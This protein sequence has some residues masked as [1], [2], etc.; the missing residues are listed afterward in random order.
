L[1]LRGEAGIGKSA[2]LGHLSQAA[3]GLTVVRCAGVEPEM[4]LPFAGLHELCSPLLSRLDALPEPQRRAVGVALG[5][6]SGASPDRLLVALGALGLLAASAGDPLLCVVEDAHWLDQASAQVLGF[7]GRRLMAE[8]IGLV[9]A[10][11]PPL[12][13]PDPLI[14]LQELRVEGLGVGPAQTL[15]ASLSSVPLD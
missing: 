12:T 5:L 10:A 14:G 4:E 15:L 6:E 1:V 13:Q 11:R 2:L 9:F 8:P 7:I 3:A